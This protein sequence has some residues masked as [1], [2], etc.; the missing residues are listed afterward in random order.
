MKLCQLLGNNAN[1]A[2]DN[3][4]VTDDFADNIDNMHGDIDDVADA[5]DDTVANDNV[6]VAY[7]SQLIRMMVK[8]LAV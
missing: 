3:D 2:Y 1:V 6:D 5:K 7:K 8:L 4:D